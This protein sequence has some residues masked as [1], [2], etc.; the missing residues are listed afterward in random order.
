MAA[1]RRASKAGVLSADVPTQIKGAV[2]YLS[3][4]KRGET[5]CFYHNIA[6][7][8]NG[9]LTERTK[10]TRTSNVEY[11]AEKAR[12]PTISPQQNIDF[13]TVNNR[14]QQRTQDSN[15]AGRDQVKNEVSV[16]FSILI[17]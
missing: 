16:L 12:Q 7:L 15:D 13:L 6:S 11:H 9:V 8:V 14:P 17:G 2:D 4:V 1:G 10:D 3:Q 5:V